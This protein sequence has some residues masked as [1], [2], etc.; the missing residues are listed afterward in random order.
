MVESGNNQSQFLTESTLGRK[1]LIETLD[2]QGCVMS[3]NELQAK[4]N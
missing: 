4:I 3:L 2:I 1:K